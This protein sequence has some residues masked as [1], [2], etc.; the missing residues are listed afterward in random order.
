MT[1]LR[2]LLAFLSISLILPAQQW[3]R[4]ED[5]DPAG[6]HAWFYSQRA[7]PAASIPPGARR[8][9]MLQ[10]TV[11]DALARLQ[12]QG[13]LPAAVGQNSRTVAAID[14]G[15]GTLIGPRPTDGGTTRARAGRVNVIAM[16]PRNNDVIYI[17]A[18]E[19]G[20]WKTTDGGVNWTPLTDDQASLANGAIALDPNHPDTV[21]VGTGEENFAQDSY[22]GAGILK[23]PD[24]GKA[25][26]N[27]V[28]PFLRAV[29][30]SMAIHPANG[31]V[32]LLTTSSGIWRSEDGAA[33][34]TRVLSGVGT[35]VL[36]DPTNGD[37][38]YAALGNTGGSA[39][40]GGY[41]ATDGGNTW[42]QVSQNGANNGVIHVDQHF[43]VFTPD[44]S[45]L[46]IANDGGMYSTTDAGASRVNWADLNA[47]LAI[48]QFYPNFSVHPS[49]PNIGIGGTQD[50]G[51]QRYSGNLSW[52]NVTCGD[53]GSTALDPSP[54]NIAYSACQNIDIRTTINN[55]ASW[56]SG[57]T[58]GIDQKDRA[59]FIAPLVIDRWNPQTLYFGTFRLWRSVDSGGKWAAASPDLTG[60]RAT[61]KTIASAAR[62]SNTVY[63]R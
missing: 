20:V 4:D 48:T 21:Y 33:N 23:S 19:G 12:R 45:K 54:P 39:L 55:G 34:W 63:V 11:T 52:S 44:G 53:G 15:D 17:G 56:T 60:G 38:A 10:I 25:W 62:G 28:G 8:Y 1:I 16:D 7:S 59:Q 42:A 49:D 31:Q 41:K 46:Y 22:Y 57:N 40:N 58:Y 32:I 13:F 51:T 5:D 27:I 2:L 30:G 3:E 61:I 36:F 47:T 35:F 14:A 37:I 43:F 9:A 24:G 6:R 18:A 50:N 26:T 29:I